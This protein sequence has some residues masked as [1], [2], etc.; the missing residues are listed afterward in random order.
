MLLTYAASRQYLKCSVCNTCYHTATASQAQADGDQ[1]T[2][3]RQAPHPKKVANCQSY[4][5]LPHLLVCESNRSDENCTIN[6]NVE[7]VS[8]YDTLR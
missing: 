1:E 4:L 7:L 6:L 2:V 8:F 3:L 5:T